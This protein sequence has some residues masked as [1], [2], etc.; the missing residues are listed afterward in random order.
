LYGR[1]RRY[2][3]YAP[4]IVDDAQT[5]NAIRRQADVVDALALV[6][7]VTITMVAIGAWAP[8]L[9]TIYDACSP[10]ERDAIA[11][12]GVCAEMAG[13][14]LGEDGPPVETALDS[15]MIVTPG[16]ALAKIPFV[17]PLPTASPRASRS[18]PA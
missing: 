9:S 11:R 15:R 6:P 18:A 4:M 3:F 5:A 16:S 8:G 17:M 12:L 7:S 2:V 14:F 13:V 10:G 1:R